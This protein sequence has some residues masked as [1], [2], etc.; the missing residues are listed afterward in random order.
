MPGQVL[1]QLLPFQLPF[2][3]LEFIAQTPV[4]D[5]AILADTLGYTR[6]GAAAMLLRYYKHGHLRRWQPV[7]GGYQYELSAKGEGWPRWAAEHPCDISLT[8]GS[9]FSPAREL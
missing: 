3:I 2:P 7:I 5:S 8:S 6:S 9:P 4:A 1:R